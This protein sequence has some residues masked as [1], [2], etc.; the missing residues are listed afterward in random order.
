M[1]FQEL[2]VAKKFSRL[3]PASITIL[4]IKKGRLYN[5]SKTLSGHHFM[6]RSRTGLKF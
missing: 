6:G 5:F 3:S 1:T 2:L 4:A